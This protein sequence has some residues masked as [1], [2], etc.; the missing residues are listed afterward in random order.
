MKEIPQMIGS[1]PTFVQQHC[2]LFCV[3]VIYYWNRGNMNLHMANTKWCHTAT[4]N[5]WR[6]FPE[7]CVMEGLNM[8]ISS[9]NLMVNWMRKNTLLIRFVL[10]MYHAS[11]THVLFYQ[12]VHSPSYRY[13]ARQ[14]AYKI[15]PF[16]WLSVAVLTNNLEHLR[17]IIINNMY[18]YIY[19]G[20]SFYWI[21]HP[22]H[23][24]Q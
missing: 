17:F 13:H 3:G 7:R 6:C 8:F 23:L 21:G 14:Q 11:F 15:K 2:L 19:L 22:S 16:S 10:E 9:F 20:H 24:L 12:H 4:A 18:L 5:L 1:L